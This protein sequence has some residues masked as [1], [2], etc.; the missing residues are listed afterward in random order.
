MAKTPVVRTT[1]D[2]CEALIE[3]D[4]KAGS[5]P[6]DGAQAN[7]PPLL[8]LQ[9]VALGVEKTIIFHDLCAGCRSAL[10]NYLKRV[11]KEPQP[12][13]TTEAAA[14]ETKPEQAEAAAPAPTT[15]PADDKKGAPADTGASKDAA[16]GGKQR[17]A[18]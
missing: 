2:R 3:E 8:Q 16:K 18:N 4:E 17:P 1:C 14:A 13:K 6:H 9:A 5:L 12:K 15:P 7:K 10:T 11:I